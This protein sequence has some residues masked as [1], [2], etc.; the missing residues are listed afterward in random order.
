MPKLVGGRAGLCSIVGALL[1]TGI[2]A[3]VGVTAAAAASGVDLKG[4]YQLTGAVS[5]HGS[6]V[7]PELVARSCAAIGSHGT[8]AAFVGGPN[9]FAVPSPLP[10]TGSAE[11]IYF[12]AG[13]MYKGPGTFSK[14][15]IL[16]GGGTDII[17]GP[18]SYNAVAS[19]ATASMTVRANGSGSFTFS[20]ASP[21][22]AGKSLSGRVTWTCAQ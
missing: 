6:F 21:V 2:V 14:E 22:K 8:G 17:V 10:P 4:S 5:K 15:D 9:H 13:V 3:G 18:N 12:T 7:D 19:A 16:K 20:N 11:N 1:A